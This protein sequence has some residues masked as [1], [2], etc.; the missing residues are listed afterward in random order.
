LTH[1]DESGNQKSLGL[2]GFTSQHTAFLQCHATVS[3]VAAVGKVF[4]LVK[5]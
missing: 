4:T 5:M 1:R 3:T 2:K